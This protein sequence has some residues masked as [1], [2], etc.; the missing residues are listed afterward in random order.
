MNQ[1]PQHVVEISFVD[2]QPVAKP[3]SIEVRQGENVAFVAASGVTSFELDFQESP[4]ESGQELYA[5][6]KG[7]VKLTVKQLG[8][9]AKYKKGMPKAEWKRIKYDVVVNG[10]RLDPDILI[11]PG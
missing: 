11:D 10:V 5:G 6:E 7:H 1:H 3:P 4:E 8:D 9:T 2:G